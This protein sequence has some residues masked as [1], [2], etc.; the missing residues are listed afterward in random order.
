MF[1]VGG[2]GGGSW[3]NFSSGPT[4]SETLSVSELCV[5]AIIPTDRERGDWESRAGIG[6]AERGLGE[7]SGDWEQWA[8]VQQV[9]GPPSPPHP[10]TWQ[11][12][13]V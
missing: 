2:A 13:W 5:A 3:S 12:T 10:A 11:H 7:Q 8:M 4:C 9:T 6:R 1:H